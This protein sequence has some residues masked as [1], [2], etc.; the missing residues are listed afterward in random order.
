MRVLITGASGLIGSALSE[1][2]RTDGHEVLALARTRTDSQQPYWNLARN[3]IDLAPAGNLNA[4]VHLAGENI[5]QRWSAKARERIYQ[6]RVA[7]TRLL[8]EA[9]MALPFRPKVLLCASATG[10]YGDRDDEVLTE[11]SPPGDSFLAKV[12]RDWESA[13]AQVTA[14]GI[15]MVNLRLGI[16]LHPSGGALGKMLPIFR[17]GLGGKLGNGRQYWSWIALEDAVR[18][19]KYSLANDTISGPV[20]VVSPNPVTNAEFTKILARVLHRPAWFTVPR[21]ALKVA[22]GEMAEETMFVSFRVKPA[23]LESA[24]FT[25]RFAELQPALENMLVGK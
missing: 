15:R 5:A 7:G 4:V 9:L 23:R 10:I 18:A 11:A 17:V 1:S 6:S 20:N 21:L 22:L 12:V 13:T 24:E 16:V 25:F 8:C 19:I 3:E 2:L 14:A